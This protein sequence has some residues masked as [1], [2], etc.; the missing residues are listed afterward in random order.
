MT[1]HYDK[2]HLS[3]GIVSILEFILQND[4]KRKI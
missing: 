2:W 1:S 3:E 4:S